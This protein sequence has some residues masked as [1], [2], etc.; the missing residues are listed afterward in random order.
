[1]MPILTESAAPP[2]VELKDATAIRMTAT[3][4]GNGRLIY[5]SRPRLMALIGSAGVEARH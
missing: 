2:D 1:M 5:S 3:T 4:N